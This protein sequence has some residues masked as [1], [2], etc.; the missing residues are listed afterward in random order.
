MTGKMHR[1]SAV[2]FAATQPNS[3]LVTVVCERG[4]HG[5][6]GGRKGCRRVDIRRQVLRPQMN[7]E[8]QTANVTHRA[9]RQGREFGVEKQGHHAVL[10]ESDG[11]AKT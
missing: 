1:P 4:I 3:R 6:E 10:Q 2:I 9:N 11:H 7:G 5:K 8:R